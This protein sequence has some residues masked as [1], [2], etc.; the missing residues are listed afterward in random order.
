MA[1][2][3]AVAL[4][5]GWFSIRWQIGNML[6]SLTQPNAPN[7]AAIA[8]FAYGLSPNDPMTNWLRA[9]IFKEDFTNDGAALSVASFEDMVRNAPHDHRA[10]VELARGL[11]Q[12]EQFERSEKAFR[13]AVELAPNYSYSHWHLANFYLRRGRE[14]EAINEFRV[15]AETSSEYR[16]Q[17]LSIAWEYFDKDPKRL[18]ELTGS[19]P[20]VRAGLA[21]FYAAKELAPESLRVWNSLTPEEKQAH[22]DIARIVTQ[23][24]YEKRYFRSAASFVHQLAIE[25]Q[26]KIGEVQNGGF[27]SPIL[28]EAQ[29]VY[30]NWKIVKLDKV[31]AKPDQFKKREGGRSLRISFNGFTGIEIK[32]VWQ[33]VAVESS[34]RYRLRFWVRTE[35]LKSAGTPLIEVVNANDD[36]IIATSA[37]FPTETNEWSEIKLEFSTPANAEGILLRLDRAYCGDAC[38]IVG[39]VWIDDVKLES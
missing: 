23:A 17:V 32:N 25:P 12:A 8:D 38:P 3:I 28:E 24:L 35:N 22:Q 20:E 27:E 13:R 29:K 26:A 2:I 30:F 11:E 1:A 21:K 34:K 37:A 31:E 36:K 19:K 18:E 7:A 9:S 5:F 33:V 16:E 39:T 15:A 10:W 6:G 14:T 4:L